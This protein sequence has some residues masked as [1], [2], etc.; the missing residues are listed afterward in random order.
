MKSLWQRVEHDLTTGPPPR[1]QRERPETAAPGERARVA[2]RRSIAAYALAVALPTIVAVALLPLRDD[3]SQIVAL[4]LVVPVVVVG[5]LGALGPALVA[6]SVAGLAFDVGFTEPYGHVVIDDPDDVVTTAALVVVA[7][8]VG[9]LCSRVVRLRAS[10]TARSRELGAVLRY[11][12][13]AVTER[14]PDLLAD[15]ACTALSELLGLRACRWQAGYHGTAG[16]VLLPS[17]ALMGALSVLAGDRA[18]LPSGTEIPAV[19]GSRELGRFVVTPDPRAAVSIEERR[20][21]LAIVSL[22]AAAAS[23]AA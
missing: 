22:F 9:G 11:A 13:V 15:A 2:R 6:A 19:H 14:D 7:V 21:A 18:V 5:A 10:D 8:V 23:R 20:T 4:V 17:G 1:R 3:H 16:P 12:E